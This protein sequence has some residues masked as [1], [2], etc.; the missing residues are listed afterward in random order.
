VVTWKQ[1]LAMGVP[2]QTL[3][4]WIRRGYVRHRGERGDRRYLL[5]DLVRRTA[6]NRRR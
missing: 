3:L 5:R 1:A 4:F 2:K 6:A